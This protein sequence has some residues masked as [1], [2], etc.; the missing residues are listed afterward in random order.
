MLKYIVIKSTDADKARKL[1]FCSGLHA[2][3]M[4]QNANI[5]LL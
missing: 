5:E 1:W 3:Q 4:K 2:Q